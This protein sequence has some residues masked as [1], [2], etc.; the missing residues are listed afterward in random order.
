MM[1]VRCHD[2]RLGTHV[3]PN[4]EGGV[5]RSMIGFDIGGTFTM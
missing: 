1:C 4:H 2:N 3:L 5:V